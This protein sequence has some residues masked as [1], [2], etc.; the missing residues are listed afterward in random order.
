MSSTQLTHAATILERLNLKQLRHWLIGSLD[1]HGSSTWVPA[2]QFLLTRL[3]QE[4]QYPGTLDWVALRQELQARPRQLQVPVY[5]LLL[6]DLIEAEDA[7]EL[8]DRLL[9]RLLLAHDRQELGTLL[10]LESL[11]ALDPETSPVS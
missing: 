9:G 5:R 6:D 10:D 3:R 11:L 8:A 2:D 1:R 7:G 4:Q